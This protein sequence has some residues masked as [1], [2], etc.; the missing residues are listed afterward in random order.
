MDCYGLSK[1]SYFLKNESKSD[2]VFINKTK[3]SKNKKIELIDTRQS[4]KNRS[5]NSIIDGSV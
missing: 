1:K 3:K 4:V 2:F 5:N